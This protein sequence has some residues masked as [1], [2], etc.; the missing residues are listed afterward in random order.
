[1]SDAVRL[2]SV[3]RFVHATPGAWSLLVAAFGFEEL[4]VYGEGD[5]VE[6]AELTWAPGGGVMLGSMP[7]AGTAQERTSKTGTSS[8][9]VLT[10]APCARATV[11]GA[12]R[13]RPARHRLRLARLRHPGPEG[14]VWSFGTYR[15]Q[16]GTAEGTRRRH[17]EL[18]LA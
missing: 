10:D 16:P 7:A 9:Y 13:M 14:K 17:R 15:G 18:R 6:H 11:A 1:M 5:T 2:P 4:V 8:I 12:T 3:R